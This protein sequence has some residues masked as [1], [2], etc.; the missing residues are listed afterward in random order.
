MFF[1]NSNNILSDHSLIF[2]SFKCMSII[3]NDGALGFN[4]S[5]KQGRLNL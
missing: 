5:A 3:L 1:G 4:V 2:L